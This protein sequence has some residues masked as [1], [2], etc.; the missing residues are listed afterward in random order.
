MG[1]T[2]GWHGLKSTTQSK[3]DKC[4][5]HGNVDR[6]AAIRYVFYSSITLL[7]Y[8]RDDPYRPKSSHSHPGSGLALTSHRPSSVSNYSSLTPRPR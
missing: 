7:V 3:G 2:H 8:L 1:D 6:R 4:R 5:R